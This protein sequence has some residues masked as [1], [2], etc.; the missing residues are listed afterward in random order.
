MPWKAQR[1][2][3]PPQAPRRTSLIR[4]KPFRSPLDWLNFCLADVRGG[5]GP[6][7]GIFLLT[8]QHW[9]QA[10][11]GV[12]ATV[13]SIVGLA[14]QTPIGAFIDAS[15][16]KRAIIIAG[17]VMLSLSAMA[18]AFAPD[19]S[20]VLA[21]QTIMG[22]AGDVFP[23]AVAAITLGI[24]GTHGLASRLGR[25][26]AF[27]HAGNVSI[28]L[29]AGFVGWAFSQTA[30]FLLVPL[31]SLLAAWS[32]LAIPPGAIDDARARGLDGDGD[33]H[34]PSG[35]SVLITCKPLLTFAVCIAFF[36]FA[37]AAMLPLV[38]QK[39][40]LANKGEETA[41]MSACVV[42][43]QVVMLP[44]A[45]LVGRKADGWGRKPICL[46]AFGI[47]PIRGVLYTFSDDRWW[48]IGVQLLDGV[49]A[50]ILSALVPLMLADLMRGTGRYNVSQ[51]V[52]ATTQGIGASLSNMVA[53]L[54]VV[55][56][57]YSAAFLT[58]AGVALVAFLILLLA[59]PETRDFGGEQSDTNAVAGLKKSHAQWT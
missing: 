31:F 53:G 59:M 7:V 25:N 32:V 38:G 4:T 17:V 47:L 28:A 52:I 36:H 23:P 24:L 48:L 54:I 22:V 30:V 12:V 57:G 3:T 41:L 27:D 29:T 21:A 15:H 43:A 39:L 14:L 49:G 37:N 9:N 18:I 50:G 40:A 58:L 46:A 10:Q 20:V 8:E 44:M 35:W 5:L 51:G 33:M 1:N 11:I 56:A 34:Q 45:L 55:S 6:Y 13:A 2:E 26:A 16:W 19:F 42:A